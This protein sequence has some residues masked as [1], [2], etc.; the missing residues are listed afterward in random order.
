MSNEGIIHTS[1]KIFS[2]QFHPEAAGACCSV[3]FCFLIILTGRRGA[4]Y[5]FDLSS[6]VYTLTLYILITSL[7][8][9]SLF[10][11]FSLFFS[12]FLSFFSLFLSFSLFF[13]FSLFL[14]SLP[15]PLPPPPS[16]PPE[17]QVVHMILIFYFKIF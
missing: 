12:L 6:N 2:V 15:T 7:D 4:S 8:F 1:K 5:H 13:S 17:T 10:L 16:P 11:S 9:F 3:F 14:S